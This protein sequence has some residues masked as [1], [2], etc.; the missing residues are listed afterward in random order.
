MLVHCKLD[1]CLPF[2]RYVCQ[3]IYAIT[4]PNHAVLFTFTNSLTAMKYGFGRHVTELSHQEVSNYLKVFY[5]GQLSWICASTT[6]KLAVLLFYWRIFPSRTFHRV[7]Y[8]IATFIICW[9][10][11]CIVTYVIQCNPVYL[12]WEPT[13]AGYCINRNQFYLASAILGLITDVVLVTMPMPI[14]WGLRMA[15]KKKFALMVVFLMGGW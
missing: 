11:A 4:H 14:V 7:I 10:I 8:G 15:T 2:H 5:T 9:F 3:D 13:A 6:V 1:L 12:F